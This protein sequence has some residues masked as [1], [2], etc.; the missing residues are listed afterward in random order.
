M[1]WSVGALVL[2]AGRGTRLPVTGDWSKHLEPLRV[3]QTQ[4]PLLDFV[5]ER[6]TPADD[7]LVA[8]GHR[9]A[10]AEAALREGG[11][12]ARTVR[13]ADID[14]LPGSIDACLGGLA[15]DVAVVVE[16]D[17]IAARGEMAR[18]L[19]AARHGPR[20]P[21][22]LLAGPKTPEPG[23]VTL[24]IC[25]NGR[26]V[27]VRRCLPGDTFRLSVLAAAVGPQLRGR[28][29]EL[30]VPRE[31]LAG[32]VSGV[33]HRVAARLVAEG[34]LVLAERARDG[35]VN[36]NTRAALRAAQEYVSSD[37]EDPGQ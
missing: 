3:G 12:G 26:V 29:G 32:L 37:Q 36:V 7:L 11:S 8:V 28:I 15:T 17:V 10:A 27:S 33:W 21:L 19:A 31:P 1:T 4:R 34:G 2:A 13:V 25:A 22:R 5:L 9:A 24:D 20:V 6:V 23:Y 35:G 16:G 18:F 30:A 14:D